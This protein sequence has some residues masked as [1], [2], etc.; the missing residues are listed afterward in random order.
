LRGGSPGCAG[1]GGTLDR[2][3]V[4]IAR[5]TD[6][7]LNSYDVIVPLS[8]LPVELAAFGHRSDLPAC[9]KLADRK[10]NAGGHNEVAIRAVEEFQAFREKYR[11]LF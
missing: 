5:L 9:W 8:E 3:G 11:P 4:A 7:R 1:D 2:I 6:A 10:W